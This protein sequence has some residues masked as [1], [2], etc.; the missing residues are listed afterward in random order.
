M[1]VKTD[2][3]YYSCALLCCSLSLSLF[4]VIFVANLRNLFLSLFF[5]LSFFLWALGKASA[6]YRSKSQLER[7]RAALVTSPLTGEWH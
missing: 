4:L 5:S 6:R 7:T 2:G 1:T 3:C